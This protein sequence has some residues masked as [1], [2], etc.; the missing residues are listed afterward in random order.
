VVRGLQ[1]LTAMPAILHDATLA[2]RSLRRTPGFTATAVL[3]LALGIGA[4]AAIFTVVNGVLLKALPF[5]DVDRVI[6]VR[7]A[8]KTEIEGGHSAGGYLDLGRLNHSLE[9]LAGYRSDFVAVTAGGQEPIQLEAAYVTSAFFDVVGPP[10][11]IGRTFSPAASTG[12]Q[13]VLSHDAW[14]QLFHDDPS[15]IGATVR[16]SGDPYV[17]SG[18]MP[19][20][21]RWPAGARVWVLSDKAV[22]PSPIDG[23]DDP[24]QRDIRY[25]DAVAR[26]RSGWSI[27]QAQADLDAVA[28]TLSR[29]HPDTDDRALRALPLREEIV[30]DVRP[31][32][33]V[34]QAAV[35]VVLLIA[36]ANVSSL[37]LAR[38]FGR[39]RELAI[40]AA[41]GAGRRHLLRQLLTESLVLGALG[42]V[43]GLLLGAWLVPVL[44]RLAPSGV[45]GHQS[46]SLDG[47]VTL[48]TTIAALATGLLFG[49][50]PA[51]QA[52]H[53][54]AIT[55]IRESGDRAGSARGR[56]RSVLVALEIALTLVLLA[57]AGL[58]LNSFLRLERVD[59]GFQPD[60]V[61]VA[62]LLVPQNR[63][64]TG[65]QQVALYRQ[66]LERLSQR[67]DLQAVGIGFPGPLKGSNASGTFYPEGRDASRDSSFANFST[68]SGGYFRAMGLRL[69]AGRTFAATDDADAPG[70][71]VINETLARQCWP[72]ENTLGKR[73]KLDRDPKAPWATVVGIVS[74]AR[75]LGLHEPPPGTIYIPYPQF[76]LPFTTVAVRSALPEGA[77][78]AMLRA[79]LTSLDPNLAWS[80]ITALQSVFNR[81]V[82]QPRFRTLLICLF[83]GLALLLAAVGVYGLVSY[84]VTQRAREFGIR[85]ALGARPAQ[86]L[87]PVLRDGA[88]LVLVGIALGVAGALAATRVLERFLFGIGAA[89]PLTFVAVALILLGVTLLASYLP[90][91]R[92][93]RVDPLTV[94]RQ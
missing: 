11:E 2:L 75:Q 21:F 34:L 54:N 79:D 35:G 74:D 12:R 61:V 46:L 88:I 3:T 65:A 84:S 69:V 45:L 67:G 89:D 51:L 64:P 80:D 87:L 57:S 39:R 49:L 71:I 41:L 78:A 28:A 37:L 62:G 43:A 31:A 83:A 63:Y 32:L 47:T 93:A 50:L 70:V 36:C 40:R 22:P 7:S 66:L 52:S 44:L 10:I 59:S 30:G 86:V 26:V 55:A 6:R 92:A 4:N 48:V 17:L 15:A 53:A 38:T 85:M 16:V 90:S 14:H 68:V 1:N 20:E 73:I 25:F 27:A 58:L 23:G 77:V 56:A 13:L 91:R 42:G 29:E 8:T 82:D 72:G 9:A 76:P 19:A 33:V 81:S 18:V 5:R 60:R 24:A 94:L